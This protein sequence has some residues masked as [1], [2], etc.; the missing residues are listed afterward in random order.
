MSFDLVLTDPP[1]GTQELSGGYGRRQDWGKNGKWTGLIAGDQNLDAFAQAF[2]LFLPMVPCGWMLVFFAPRKTPEFCERTRKAS[3]FGEVIWDKRSPG[4]GYHIRY[5]HENIAVFKCGEPERPAN[6]LFS[7]VSESVE[8]GLHPHEKP[9]HL[10]TRLAAWGCRAGGTILDPFLGS[11]TTL[12]A[13]KDLKRKAVGIEI[14]ERNC[15]I[16]AKRMAQEVLL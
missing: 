1:Y 7:V 15:E 13:A 16:A 6:A 3:W 8:A 2:E 12:R 4:L 9:L 5:S 10:F 14:D 11:G